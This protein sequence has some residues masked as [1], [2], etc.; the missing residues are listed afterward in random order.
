M[1]QTPCWECGN[2][3]SKSEVLDIPVFKKGFAIQWCFNCVI[4]QLK[5]SGYGLVKITDD[6]KEIHIKST[7]E[8][9]KEYQLILDELCF[10]YEAQV[11]PTIDSFAW[12]ELCELANQ[13]Q[14]D[15]GDEE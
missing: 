4:K 10:C 14:Y 9:G 3:Y 2:S 6:Y 13:I 11:N 12:S 1:S 5:L 8:E 7:E 15:W